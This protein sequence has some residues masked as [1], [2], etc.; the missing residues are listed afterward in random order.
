M[1][2]DDDLKTA[3]RSSYDLHVEERE[4]KVQADWKLLKRNLF[5][6]RLKEVDRSSILD[7]GAG[8]GPD[9]DGAAL[10]DLGFRVVTSDGHSLSNGRVGIG[11]NGLLR[12][13]LPRR[14]LQRH[15]VSEHPAS[16]SPA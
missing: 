12:H 16:R 1:P 4:A 11:P 10:Q 14:N 13:P 5:A 2:V 15:L 9:P 3:L 8:T 7:I 6:D